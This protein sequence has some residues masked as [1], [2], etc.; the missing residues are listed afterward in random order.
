[1]QKLEKKSVRRD[2]KLSEKEVMKDTSRNSC[3]LSSDLDTSIKSSPCQEEATNPNY[4]YS[5]NY[6]NFKPVIK[7]PLIGSSFKNQS[8]ISLQIQAKD[9]NEKILASNNMEEKIL[10]SKDVNQNV[11]HKKSKS[12]L[13]SLKSKSFNYVNFPTL[14]STFIFCLLLLIDSLAVSDGIRTSNQ[15]SQSSLVDV[16]QV[17][18]TPFNR[19]SSIIPVQRGKVSSPFH[20]L[21]SSSQL[22]LTHISPSSSSVSSSSPSFA[23][24]SPFHFT[25]LSVES[26]NHSFSYLPPLESLQLKSRPP[27]LSPS[28]SS[29]S[30]SQSFS[31]ASSPT[32]SSPLLMKPSPST[33]DGQII[34]VSSRRKTSSDERRKTTSEERWKKTAEEKRKIQSSEERKKFRNNYHPQNTNYHPPNRDYNH[35]NNNRNNVIFT[36]NKK[37]SPNRKTTK[38]MYLFCSCLH[39]S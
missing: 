3:P 32:L 39:L 5:E 35:W 8:K 18:V 29:S 16:P 1:M 13:V 30:S 2:T 14:I 21:P 19:R 4:S 28:I 11:S 36:S 22:S 9:L 7:K 25:S 23:S 6:C 10:V 12:H 34:V 24:S 26:S 31:S 20:F 37:R 15:W 33:L 17:Q 38:G 27:S